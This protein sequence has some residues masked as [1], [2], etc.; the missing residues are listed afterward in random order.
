MLY[1]KIIHPLMGLIL[2]QTISQNGMEINWFQA[3]LVMMVLKAS[4]Q[5]NAAISG[6]LNVSG[7]VVNLSNNTCVR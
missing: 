5:G 1:P 4:I 2:Q 7:Q 6:S 3:S